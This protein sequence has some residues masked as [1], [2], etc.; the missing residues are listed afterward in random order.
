MASPIEES[1][2]ESAASSMEVK[3]STDEMHFG[4]AN[5]S[6]SVSGFL[7]LASRLSTGLMT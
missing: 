7:R 5:S 2:A 3:P 4:S 6:A 1:S